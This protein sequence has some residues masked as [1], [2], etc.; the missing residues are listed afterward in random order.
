M[1]GGTT[2]LFGLVGHPVTHVRT[3]Q[4]M[5]ALF[6]RNGLDAVMVP[7]DVAGADLAAC[8]AGLQR[9]RNLEGLV[10]TVP[11]KMSAVELCRDLTPRAG[12]AGAV[13]V[14]RRVGED[15]FAGDMLDGEGFVAGLAAA[16]HAVAGRRICLVGAGGA[17]SAIA[18]ALAERQPAKLTLINR[19]RERLLALHE[20]LRSRFP[21]LDV[22]IG[23]QVGGHDLVVNA[24]SLGLRADD[25]LPFDPEQVGPGVVVA[26]VIMTPEIT[27]IL[28]A[29]A[30][31]GA[32][33]HPGRAMLDGQLDAIFRYF[34]EDGRIPARQGRGP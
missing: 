22:V 4:A 25:P 3:P 7:F 5:N 26:E 34:S 14:L 18:V 28:H 27:P 20:R 21:A 32:A 33:I 9:I 19:S 11:H 29:A 13:N 2:K 12:L 10:V 24:T 16:G 23:E 17:A 1:I 31:R 30:R 6:E 8:L 15:A